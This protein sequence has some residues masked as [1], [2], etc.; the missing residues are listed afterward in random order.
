MVKKDHSSSD[1]LAFCSIPLYNF[2]WGIFKIVRKWCRKPDLYQRI[3]S[4]NK[5]VPIFAY[6]F[7]I[8]SS[9]LAL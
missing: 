3:S 1:V 4:G 6:D 8:V 2:S 5:G 7:S 9:N